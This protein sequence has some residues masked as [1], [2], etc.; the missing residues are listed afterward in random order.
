MDELFEWVA[1]ETEVVPPIVDGLLLD[2]EAGGEPELLGGVVGVEL[3][4][5]LDGQTE[6][7]A[8]D[9]Q[10]VPNQ[11]PGHPVVHNLKD[12]STAVI[13]RTFLF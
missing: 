5:L 7:L 11:C 4:L 8:G 13:F 3:H 10:H 1:V 12:S 2:V 6:E 9:A